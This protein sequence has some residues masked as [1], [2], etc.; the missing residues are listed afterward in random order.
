M[1]YANDEPEGKFLYTKLFC[2]VWHY[3]RDVCQTH[4]TQLSRHVIFLCR[5]KIKYFFYSGNENN[6]QVRSFVAANIRLCVGI[7]WHGLALSGM[8]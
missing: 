1:F 8:V 3:A 4:E 5:N 2:I 6:R 7:V